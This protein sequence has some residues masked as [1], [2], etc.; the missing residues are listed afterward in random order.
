MMKISNTFSPNFIVINI[1]KIY[2]FIPLFLFYPIRARA[3]EF[4][5]R[6][7]GGESVAVALRS[8]RRKV[9]KEDP[10]NFTDWAVFSIQG[11]P[12]RRFSV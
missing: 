12:F 10:L 11:D 4:Y 7:F 5:R 6:L 2:Y 1:L 3:E 8:A 9:F